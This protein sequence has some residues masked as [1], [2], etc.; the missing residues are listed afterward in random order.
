MLS[1]LDVAEGSGDGAWIMAVD[2]P[3]AELGRLCENVWAACMPPAAD[4]ESA[5]Q[6]SAC[7]NNAPDGGSRFLAD[8]AGRQ[9]LA[10]AGT[11]LQARRGAYR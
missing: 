1:F 2:A 6:G 3:R 8:W 4:A 9:S 5:T 7:D 11:A 10:L